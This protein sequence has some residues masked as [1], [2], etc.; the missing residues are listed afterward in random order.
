MN[1]VTIT[2]NN[3]P[4]DLLSGFDLTDKERVEFDYIE[5]MGDT[6]D[7]FFR[8][9]GNVYDMHEFV[10]IELASKRTNPYCL[11]VYEED[12]PLLAWDGY[13]SDSM[14][15]GI[16]VRYCEDCSARVVVGIVLS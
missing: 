12:S 8:Y 11:G 2:T 10:R 4:R 3:V 1:D 7:R 16:V 15:S 5:D 6:I 14:F 9:R 13:Q